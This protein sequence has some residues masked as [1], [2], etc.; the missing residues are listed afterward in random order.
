MYH[1]FINY[2]HGVHKTKDVD[3]FLK[4]NVSGTIFVIQGERQPYGRICTKVHVIYHNL[5]DIVALHAQNEVLKTSL[6]NRN[7]LNLL[8]GS[9]APHISVP[10]MNSWRK[11]SF[12]FQVFFSSVCHLEVDA[13]VPVLV[14]YSEQLVNI[15]FLGVFAGA[16]E[17]TYGQILDRQN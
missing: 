16:L 1:T 6:G 7:H 17:E 3:H 10:I 13:P 8:S 9:L 14:K 11:K 15:G 12:F 5:T 2:L 4:L